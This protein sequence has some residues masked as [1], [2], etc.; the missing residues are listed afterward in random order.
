MSTAAL[1][2]AI[3]HEHIQQVRQRVAEIL[4]RLVNVSGYRA[5]LS[6]LRDQIYEVAERI[7]TGSEPE[8]GTQRWDLLHCL[9]LVDMSIHLTRQMQRILAADYRLTQLTL[10]NSSLNSSSNNEERDRR[11]STSSDSETQ[12]PVHKRSKNS[13]TERETRTRSSHSS[14]PERRDPVPSTSSG[15]TR[16]RYEYNRWLV[17]SRS[18]NSTNSPDVFTSGFS[19]PT[20]R[21]SGPESSDEN[22]EQRSQ[23]LRPRSPPLSEIHQVLNS[24]VN[25]RFNVPFFGPQS[26][27]NNPTMPSQHIWFSGGPLSAVS[28]FSDLRIIGGGGNFNYRIQCWNFSR[29]EL[30]NLKDAQANLVVPKCRIHNDASVDISKSGDL[31]ACLVPVDSSP[32]VNLC[33]YSLEKETFAQCFYVWTFGANA[34]SVSLSPLS[35]YVVVG[36]TSPRSS[37]IYVYPPSTEPVTIAQVFKLSGHS[38]S[39][40]PSF[41][42]IRNIEVPRGDDVFNLN[43]ICWLPNSGE[44]LIYG[45]NKGHLVICRPCSSESN[46][47]PGFSR[48]STTGTQTY[49]QRTGTLSIGTQTTDALPLPDSVE[50]SSDSD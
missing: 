43:S 17:R 35:R 12:E 27:L 1:T 33:I 9:W 7:A 22:Q 50:V 20:V 26:S 15:I 25:E 32:S 39:T 19:I 49:P 18:S 16:P 42:H 2:T 30:P 29:C 10:S 46:R 4:E 5:R 47:S 40:I 34:I 28:G 44:G 24:S 31:L 38:K 13:N 11:S 48:R 8:F 36:L 23:R 45:T 21:V 3:A 14:S 37:Q 41:Q 6:N